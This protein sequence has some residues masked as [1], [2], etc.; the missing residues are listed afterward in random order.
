MGQGTK[1][2]GVPLGTLRHCG[3]VMSEKVKKQLAKVDFPSEHASPQEFLVLLRSSVIPGLDYLRRL[4]RVD[5]SREWTTIF[6]TEV[7]K[8]L[9]L[10]MDGMGDWSEGACMKWLHTMKSG[11]RRL[12]SSNEAACIASA[13]SAYRNGGLVSEPKDFGATIHRFNTNRVDPEDRIRGANFGEVMQGLPS[14][15]TRCNTS[16]WCARGKEKGESVGRADE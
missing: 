15:E 6:D 5:S 3:S 12:T 10:K 14:W 16:W 4:V 8:K 1:M 9:Q 2:A 11:V 7:L 13:V